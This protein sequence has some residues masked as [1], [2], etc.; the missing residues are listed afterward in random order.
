MSIS[1]W[2]SIDPSRPFSACALA[3]S[4]SRGLRK[5][6]KATTISTI[7]SGP[8]TNS[9]ATNSQPEQ[10][11]DDDAELEDEVRRGELERHRRREVRALAEQRAG[12]RDR[13]V[14]A[15]RGRGAEGGRL[16]HGA[17]RVVREQPL[18]LLLGHDRL[19][20]R[21]EREAQDQR[22]EDLPRHAAGEGERVQ[23]LLAD[24]DAEEHQDGWAPSGS[25]EAP[26][27]AGA[28]EG[29]RP[30]ATSSH[31][32]D[33]GDRDHDRVHARVGAAALRRGR[34]QRGAGLRGQAPDGLVRGLDE[35]LV[36][37]ADRHRADERQLRRH[38]LRR[39]PRSRSPSG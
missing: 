6:R 17:R 1:A 16:G 25:V 19:H 4:S 2:P 24:V 20:D 11:A 12:E 33:R 13:R 14:G 28:G 39:C 36:P 32:D 34:R 37:L 8:P 15:R 26:A 18:H 38:G 31:A 9:P 35:P 21:G 22:P 29:P 7:I 23:D 3:S 5:S 27:S 30:P 10:E